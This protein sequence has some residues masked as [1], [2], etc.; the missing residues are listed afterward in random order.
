M[1]DSQRKGRIIFHIDMNSFYASVE[2]AYDPS[3]RGKPLAISGNAKERKGI[4][5]T[6]SYEARALGVKPPMPLWEA[7]RLCPGLIVRTPNFDRYR[8][9]SQ[10]MFTILR[11]YSDLVEPVSI[12]EGYIDLTHTPYAEHAVKTAHDIQTRLVEE[13]MLPSSIGIAPN[14]FLAKMASNW[15]KPMGITILRKRDVP[16]MLWPL[17]AGDMHGVGQKTADKLK[18][19][20]IHTIEDLAKANEYTLKELLGINGPRLKQKANGE[21]DGNVDPERIYEF[22]SVGNSSTLPHDSDDPDELVA[23]IDKLSQSVSARLRRKEVMANRLLIMIRYASWKNITRSVTLTNP[24]D[25]KED[26]FEAARQLFLKHWNDQPVR[27]LGVTGTDLVERKA[28][29]KQLDLFSYTEDAKEEPLQTVLEGLKEKYGKSL[30]QRGMT[31]KEKESK[32]S[33]TSFNKDFF[34]DEKG[35]D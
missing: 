25:R 35:N 29:V 16:Q 19:I 30:V 7:K 22:K 31:I 17:P 13:L 5:V 21:H 8:S 18:T 4:V 6:C 3:L 28:A 11:E 24:T 23:L 15:K 26:L 32:T 33:G 12:D 20:G 9:S 34:Q 27:L 14:N 1:A 2:M 10:E